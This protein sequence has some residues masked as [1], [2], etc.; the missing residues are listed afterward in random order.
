MYIFK[1]ILYAYPYKKKIYCQ[2]R[3]TTL[4][5]KSQFLTITGNANDANSNFKRR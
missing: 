5:L 1:N 3:N 4:G 2:Y